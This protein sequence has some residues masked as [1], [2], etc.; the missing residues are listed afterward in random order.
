[1]PHDRESPR[2]AIQAWISRVSN[3]ADETSI[4]Q[5]RTKQGDGELPLEYSSRRRS[6]K[7]GA[8]CTQEFANRR[9]H[10]SPHGPS[11]Q[12]FFRVPSNDLKLTIE[13]QGNVG[14][15]KSLGDADKNTPQ[16][17]GLHAPFLSFNT[18]KDDRE[19][20]GVVG[21]HKLKRHCS[22]S[23]T[24]SYLEPAEICK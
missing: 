15:R 7:Q 21:N 8:K 12:H 3:G 23:S 18:G 20:V 17:L 14:R 11:K 9:D 2:A 13:T 19:P 4:R 24:C 1:M 6:Y 5:H 16:K 22:V 10:G